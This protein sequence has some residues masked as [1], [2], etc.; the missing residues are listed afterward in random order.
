VVVEDDC[1]MEDDGGKTEGMTEP[2]KEAHRILAIVDEEEMAAARAEVEAAGGAPAA[3]NGG[4]MWSEVAAALV[5]ARTSS[6]QVFAPPKI[7]ARTNAQ[8]DA[9][10]DAEAAYLARESEAAKTTHFV[11]YLVLAKSAAKVG[12]KCALVCVGVRACGV[13]PWTVEGC[14]RFA[15][16]W[17]KPAD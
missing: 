10:A 16:V 6:D 9:D 8:K 4:C 5:A 17:Q 15:K 2:Q 3:D 11:P 7:A 12:T 14:V 1:G 13:P